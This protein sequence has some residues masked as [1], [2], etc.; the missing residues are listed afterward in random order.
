MRY[1]VS[2]PP[3]TDPATLLGLARDA[4][5]AGWDGVFLWDHVQW[6]RDVAP[7]VLDPWVMLGAI[8][9]VTERVRLGTM[10]TPLSRRRP[11][12][13]AKH[14]ATLDRLSAG[15]VVFGVGLGAPPDRD[16]ADLGDEGDPRRRAAMLDEGLDLLDG[17]L[18]G[19]VRHAG[20]HYT[21]TAHLEPAPV[22]RPRPRFWVAAVVPHRRP[23]ARARRWDG[24]VP[25]GPADL[26]S[27]EAIGDYLGDDLPDGW[28]VVLPWSP[29]VPAA[30]YADAGA[31][32]LVESPRP[33]GDWVEELRG[34]LR[35]GPDDRP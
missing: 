7:G 35:R 21:V 27:P 3:F 31:T 9:Q 2:I 17:L 12:V 10:V 30:E 4:E 13:V 26:V 11:W 25:I 5:A 14:L 8:A 34:R 19:P 15:R 28:D 22:Q 1:A 32:W 18:R 33:D 16:F 23:L 29:G 6:S 24:I 20:Q